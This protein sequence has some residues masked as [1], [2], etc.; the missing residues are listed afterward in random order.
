M[1]SAGARA[2]S[3]GLPPVI[4]HR[5][6]AAA[7]PENTLAGLRVAHDQGARWVEF[8]VRLA[9]DGTPILLHDDRVDRTSDGKGEAAGLSLEALRRFDFGAWFG[10]GFAG[11]RIATFADTIAFLGELGMGAN[12]EIK[13]APGGEAAT[14]RATVTMLRRLW[15]GHLPAPLLSSFA[16]AALAAAKEAAPE[17]TRGHLFGRLPGDWRAQ[18]EALGCVTIHCDQRHLDRAQAQAVIAA[19]YPL[20]V[21]T[22]NDPRR[23]RDI[24]AW[25]ASSVFSDAPD[26]ILAGL[27]ARDSSN[28]AGVLT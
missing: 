13:P 5:G 7:A 3:L 28:P 11:E 16:P 24:L 27:A 10:A 26:R 9:G 23:A 19:G 14:A 25:G 15:P 21:Y 1:G 18:A 8:D 17:I 6:A 4:G 12:V 2:A 22:V 20:L